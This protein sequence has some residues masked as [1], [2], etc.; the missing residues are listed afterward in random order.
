MSILLKSLLATFSKSKAK[1]QSQPKATKS[2]EPKVDKTV[3]ASPR[4]SQ[5]EAV[6]Q[7]ENTAKEVLAFARE[8]AEKIIQTLI[9]EGEVFEIHPGKLRTTL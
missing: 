8:E 7:A 1:K 3:T 6:K 9:K 2:A 5:S 4:S